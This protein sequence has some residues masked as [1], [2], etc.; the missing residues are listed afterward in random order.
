MVADQPIEPENKQI[1]YTG[2]NMNDELMKQIDEW[3]KA[4]KHRNHRCS[5]T[6]SGSRTGF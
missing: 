2:E 5:G 6:D 1:I 3:H 4:E